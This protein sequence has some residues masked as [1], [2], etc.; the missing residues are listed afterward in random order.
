[1]MV[2]LLIL[3][4]TSRQWN[5]NLRATSRRNTEQE[6]A[7]GSQML[8][9]SISTLENMVEFVIQLNALEKL[10]SVLQR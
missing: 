10:V 1:M 5:L 8:L 3:N 7:Y 6:G 2:S 4:F 9:H